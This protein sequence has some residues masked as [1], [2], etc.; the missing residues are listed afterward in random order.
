MFSSGDFYAEI[1][2]L[3]FWLRKPEEVD[4]AEIT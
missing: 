3:D 1:V 2:H 4:I